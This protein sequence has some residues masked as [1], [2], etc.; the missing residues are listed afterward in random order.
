MRVPAVKP[1]QPNFKAHF[2]TVNPIGDTLCV[3][4]DNEKQLGEKPELEYMSIWKKPKTESCYKG[5]D[6]L[7]HSSV[8]WGKEYGPFKYK[9]IYK[10]TG[11]TDDKNG[12]YYTLDYET[13]F[14]K[15]EQCNRKTK[16]LKDILTLS[17]GKTT[18]KLVSPA[19]QEEL[20]QIAQDSKNPYVVLVKDFKVIY[21]PT[22]PSNIVGLISLGGNFEELS[23]YS[24]VI[25]SK[26]DSSAFITNKKMFEDFEKHLG[27]YVELETKKD[28]AAIKEIDKSQV[29]YTPKN[30]EIK[31]QKLLNSDKLLQ[32][33]EYTSDTVGAKALNL[34]RMEDLK[35][36]GKIDAI[37]PPSFAIPHAYLE[38][39]EKEPSRITEI[40]EM[41]EKTGIDKKNIMLRSAFNGEDLENYSAAGLYDSVPTGYYNNRE[42]FNDIKR[43]AESKWNERAV[44]SRKEHNIP[45]DDIQPTVLVQQEQPCDYIFTAYTKDDDGK[46]KIEMFSKY[47]L[48]T[49][50]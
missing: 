49:D 12:E 2:Y 4:T 21:A 6:G 32:S 39:L 42:F 9:Y 45:D 23:H 44:I 8:L 46:F 37:I 16:G 20:S 29:H 40:I 27:K 19:S 25:K 17:R 3:K 47:S 11:K 5:S 34:K 22:M 24:T 10:D 43:I 33:S 15:A 41:I 31:V 1:F 50:R 14:N 26:T 30:Q 18:G 48:I 36:K 13:I 7:F 28:F 38:N 35:Q